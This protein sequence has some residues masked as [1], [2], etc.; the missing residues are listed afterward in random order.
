MTIAAGLT[1]ALLSTAALSYGFYLQHAASGHAPTLTLRHPVASLASLFRNWR[2]LAGFTTGLAGWGL[3]IAALRLAPLSIVQAT[4]AGGIA[5]LAY[6]TRLGNGRLPPCDQA[7]VAASAGGLILLGL[8]LPAG[9][10]HQATPSWPAPLGWVAASA[11]LAALAAAPVAAPLKP[12]AGLAAAAGLLYAA[13]DVATKAAVGGT[14]PAFL[15]TGLLLACSGLAFLCLQVAFQRGTVLATAG[16]STLLT[17]ATPI[18]AGVI[19][20]SEHLPGGPA[21]IARGLGFAATILGATLL[22]ATGRAGSPDPAAHDL[23]QTKARV[24]ED[25]LTGAF[26]SASTRGGGLMPRPMPTITLPSGDEIP[27][28]EQGT[29][30]LAE[31]PAR[32]HLEIAAL[33]CGL[34]IG[35]NLIDTAEMYADGQAEKLVAEAIAGR[36]DEVFLVSKVLPHHATREGTARACQ[37]SLRRMNTDRIDL[38]LLHWRGSVPLAETVEAFLGLQ[39]AG[40]IRNWGVSNFDVPDL[41]ELISLPGVPAP[42]ARQ[43]AGDARRAAAWRCHG[44]GPAHPG[45]C[46]RETTAAH[47]GLPETRQR[48]AAARGATAA[49]LAHSSFATN[50]ASSLGTS[51]VPR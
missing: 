4:S 11:L 37:D 51:S 39:A 2:W 9:T 29:W 33:R 5:L 26:R 14:R 45:Q 23:G 40:L 48:P 38:Y 13:G 35:M 1:L 8:S 50:W 46:G 10:P 22:A 21:G 43:A 15:F 31:I 30:H 42:A 34:D 3:Y 20:F 41:E 16:V 7:A 19:V 27:V 18:L 6:L 36:R 24:S 47:N 17:N 25:R 12:G 44:H 49:P 32:R 28:L